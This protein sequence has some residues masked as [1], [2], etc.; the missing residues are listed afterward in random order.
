MASPKKLEDFNADDRVDLKLL[1]HS[2]YYLC[3]EIDT[4]SIYNCIKWILY[5]NLVAKEEK[6]LTLY[7]NS[8]GGDLYES[9]ALIDIMKGSQ[10]TIRTVGIGAV[11]SAAFLIFASGT[12]GHRMAARNASFMC[13]QYHETITGKHHD[14]KASMRDG[15]LTNQKMINVLRDATGLPATKIKTKFLSP[16]DIYLTAAEVVDLN[17]ADAII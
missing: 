1:E 13:H 8:T 17:I 14:I 3:G 16:T 6:I 9:L 11:M 12:Q 10:H 7:I 4:D 5:E 15:D 2:T